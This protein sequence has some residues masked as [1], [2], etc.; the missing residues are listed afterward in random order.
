MGW[1]SGKDWRGMRAKGINIHLHKL[2]P[3]D[4]YIV[5]DGTFHAVF[6]DVEMQPA[7]AAHDDTWLGGNPTLHYL[8]KKLGSH[9][10]R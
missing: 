10:F 7:S 3:G 5:A 9:C 1:S 8:K 6:N 2:L 4:V